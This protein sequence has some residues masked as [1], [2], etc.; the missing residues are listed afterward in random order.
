MVNIQLVVIDLS[1]SKFACPFESLRFLK[2]NFYYTKFYYSKN[3]GMYP[4]LDLSH[5]KTLGMP[6][7]LP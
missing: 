1:P 3:R 7:N 4:T 6:K 2:Q 5:Q